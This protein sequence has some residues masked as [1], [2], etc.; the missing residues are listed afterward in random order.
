VVSEGFASGWNGIYGFDAV[1]SGIRFSELCSPGPLRQE[2]DITKIQYKRHAQSFY[3]SSLETIFAA[4]QQLAHPTPTRSSPTG[5]FSSRF[6]TVCLTG[7]EEGGV[8]ILAFQVT[9]QAVA[10]VQADMIEASVDPGTVRVK[11]EEGDRY[12]PDVF[13]R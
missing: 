4:H 5:T 11:R 12:V 13:Y 2:D 1:S 10:M 9:E 3:L 8:D 7:S 6:V